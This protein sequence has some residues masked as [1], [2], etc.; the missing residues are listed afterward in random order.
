MRL[1]RNRLGTPSPTE[2]SSSCSSISFRDIMMTGVIEIYYC[3]DDDGD[4]NGLNRVSTNPD[5]EN[6]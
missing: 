5:A 1:V 4:I 3:I 6:V 2:S